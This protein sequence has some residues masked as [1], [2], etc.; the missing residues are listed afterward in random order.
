MATM[1]L[2]AARMGTLK[3]LY[4]HVINGSSVNSAGFDATW[5]W[6]L[7]DQSVHSFPHVTF[8]SDDLPVALDSISALRLAA[9][10]AMSAG[11]ITS[12]QSQSARIG[13]NYGDLSSVGAKANVAFDMFL[14]QDEEN[15]KSAVD[16]GY[17]MMVWIGQVGQPF[18]LGYDSRNA[19]CYTQQLGAFN[20]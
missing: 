5:Y 18:P 12:A 9:L 19:A 14:D 6:P 13:V 1:L 16:A 3:D 8:S 7:S 17:E 15:S 20:L 10:W 11:T 2:F 4:F